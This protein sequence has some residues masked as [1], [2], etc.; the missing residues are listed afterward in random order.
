MDLRPAIG[1]DMDETGN[2]IR[3][4]RQQYLMGMKQAVGQDLMGM[5][6]LD[7]MEMRQATG[8]DGDETG[9][10]IWRGWDRQQDLVGMGQATGSDG[11]ETGNKIWWGWDRQQDL[12][13]MGQ[14]TWPRG[15]E[16]FP[17][18]LMSTHRLP[19]WVDVHGVQMWTLDSRLTSVTKQIGIQAKNKKI[20]FGETGMFMSCRAVLDSLGE[21][22]TLIY[23]RIIWDSLKWLFFDK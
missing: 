19:T 20:L 6:H 14:A 18:T 15:D 1:S 7:L 2:R 21:I 16:A 5:R 8:S 13:G 10:K 9:N 3:W 11:N 23:P 22:R 4:D 12:V 17:R